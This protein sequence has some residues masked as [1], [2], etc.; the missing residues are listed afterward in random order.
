MARWKELFGMAQSPAELLEPGRP[1]AVAGVAD[2]AEGL[3]CADL[4][5]AVAGQR[6]APATSLLFVCRD[7][8]RMAALSRALTF[9]ALVLVIVSLIFVNRSFSTSLVEAF[10]RP[11][12]TLVIIV[13]FVTSVLALSLVWPRAADLFRFGPL[14]ADDLAVTAVVALVCFVLLELSKYPLRRRAPTSGAT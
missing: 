4:A 2:G 12:H 3:V 8:G 7:G 11:N 14:H 5:R 6:R 9:F 13:M 10:T 1:L